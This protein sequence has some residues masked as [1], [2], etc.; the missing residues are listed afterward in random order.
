MKSADKHYKNASLD[1]DLTVEMR[2]SRLNH[3]HYN[4]P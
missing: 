1:R 2:R 3:D 4:A